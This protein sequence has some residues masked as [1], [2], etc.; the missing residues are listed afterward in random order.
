[1]SPNDKSLIRQMIKAGKFSVVIDFMP[2]Y[3][4]QKS[5]E[6]I[7]TM[8]EKWCCHPKNAVKKLEV[9]LEILKQNQ[10]KFLKRK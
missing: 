1:V 8:G 3:N 9:P 6:I 10:S 4:L 7:E 5:K 2:E